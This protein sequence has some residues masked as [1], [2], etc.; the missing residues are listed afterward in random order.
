[1]VVDHFSKYATFIP[2]PNECTTED[3]INLFFKH[4]VKY[5]GLPKSIVSDHD[6]WFTG[7]FWT[8]LFKLME[9]A[10]Y[11]FTSFHPQTDEQTERMNDLLE[12]YLRCFVSVNQHDWAKLL[13]VAQFFYNLQR[14]EATS[15]SPFEVIMGQQPLTPHT[16]IMSYTGRCPTTYKVAKSWHEQA[17]TARAHLDKATM[18]MKKWADSKRRHLELWPDP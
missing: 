14:I 7:R 13:D 8:E 17:D 6:S 4:V 9:S 5:K 12:L 3:T 2:A 16:L 1:M 18:W 15:K 11:F 10:L